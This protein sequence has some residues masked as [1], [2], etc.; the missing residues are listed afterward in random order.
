[1]IF[2]GQIRSKQLLLSRSVGI[3]YHSV[4]ASKSLPL[5]AGCGVVF[6]SLLA[7]NAVDDWVVDTVCVGRVVVLYFREQIVDVHHDEGSAID[8]LDA[9]Y[10]VLEVLDAGW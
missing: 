5:I 6:R 9:A 3:L 10:W 7:V 1:M 2:D 4:S 8:E